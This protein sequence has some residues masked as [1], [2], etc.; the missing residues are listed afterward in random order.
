MP[1]D[2]FW[3]SRGEEQIS[4]RDEVNSGLGMLFGKGSRHGLESSG[5][6]K[7]DLALEAFEEKTGMSGDLDSHGVLGFY[8]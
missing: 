4:Q 2:C 1:G 7:G 6:G 5:G 8:S 3:S